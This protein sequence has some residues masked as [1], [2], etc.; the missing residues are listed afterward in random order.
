MQLVKVFAKAKGG[1][2]GVQSLRRRG[3]PDPTL[4]YVFVEN[5]RDLDQLIATSP[6][7]ES[8]RVEDADPGAFPLLLERWDGGMAWSSQIPLGAALADDWELG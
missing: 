4:R 3:D 8:V 6:A 1:Q 7:F 5:R 2:S